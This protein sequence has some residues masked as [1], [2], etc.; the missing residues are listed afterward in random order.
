MNVIVNLLFILLKCYLCLSASTGSQYSGDGR[1]VGGHE[2]KP[3]S[4]PYLVTLQLRFL[5]IRA[6]V[7]GGSILSNKWVLTAAHCIK[8]SFLTRWLPLDA[9]AGAHDV[10]NFGPKAQINAI[11][12]RFPHPLYPGGIGPYDIA[13]LQ[14]S[15]P[16]TF[17][18]EVQPINLPYNNYKISNDPLTLAGWGVLRT[19]FFIPDSPSRLQEVKVTY[20]PYQEC[21]AAI[22][23]I[24]DIDESNPLNKDANICTGPLSGGIAACSGDSGG[25]LIQ[26]A[27]RNAFNR[28]E[29]TTDDYEDYVGTEYIK[30]NS[31]EYK[32]ANINNTEIIPVVLGIVSWG[33][34]PC[35]DKG[36]PTVYTKVSEYID[37]ITE[38]TKS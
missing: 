27:P 3:Y 18:N 38:Y 34:S 29:E 2:S 11:G 6:H 23:K 15:K 13:V 21:Y 32:M 7:C 14:T 35:G 12:K 33:M 17:T 31:I 30:R 5:W 8:E 1:L 9:I 37:F 25:P 19:T 4:H 10:Y 20:I 36:A 24:K 16:F 28:I 22:E 26:Y